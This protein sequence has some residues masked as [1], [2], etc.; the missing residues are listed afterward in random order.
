MEETA[1]IITGD[2]IADLYTLANEIEE[3]MEV[4]TPGQAADKLGSLWHQIVDQLVEM[5]EPDFRE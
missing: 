1:P 2:K 4:I 3:I 5:G